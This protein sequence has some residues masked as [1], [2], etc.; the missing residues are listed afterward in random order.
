MS[1]S[2]RPQRRSRRRPLTSHRA[3]RPGPPAHGP[4]RV[5]VA[6]HATAVVL[7]VSGEFDL[8]G[9]DH[10]ERSFDGAVDALTDC[11]VFD[12]R[13][14]SFLDLSGLGTLV[15]AGARARRESF[16]LGVV[17]PHGAGARIFTATDAGREL[18]MLED[19]P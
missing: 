3:R 16:A 6:H 15:R 8:S 12:L 7:R 13:D 14:V 1:S 10:V 19:L 5:Q 18:R 17:P 9:V 4:V 2:H 11:V